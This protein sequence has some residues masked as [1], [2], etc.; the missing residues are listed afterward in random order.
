MTPNKDNQHKEGRCY[1]CNKQGHLARNCPN[2]PK[3][4][5]AKAK[6]TKI[7]EESDDETIYQHGGKVMA[8]NWD[9]YMRAGVDL[10]EED[11]LIII[12]KAAEWEQG[13]DNPEEDF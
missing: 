8:A 4:P 6:S 7:E 11:K 9:S 2:K 13:Q 3:Q 5:P 1:T 10:P 12:W